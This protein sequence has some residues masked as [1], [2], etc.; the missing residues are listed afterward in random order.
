MAGRWR[1]VP[2]TAD[3]ALAVTGENLEEVLRAAA[4]GLWSVCWDV[5]QVRA[6]L[7]WEITAEGRDVETLL[8]NFLNELIFQHETGRVVWR[9]LERLTVEEAPGG[10]LMVRAA[11]K[12]EPLGPRHRLRREV[13]AA[14]LHGLRVTRRGGRLSAQVVFDL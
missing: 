6:E 12:G 9:E 7:T 11:V 10:G 1:V 14:T 3:L 2:H 8:V 13:K 4:V 5:R